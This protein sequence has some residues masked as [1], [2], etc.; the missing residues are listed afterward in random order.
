MKKISIK[1]FQAKLKNAQV[2]DAESKKNLKGG[3]GDPPPWGDNKAAGDPPPW[4]DQ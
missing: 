3:I 4:G 2:I 1:N